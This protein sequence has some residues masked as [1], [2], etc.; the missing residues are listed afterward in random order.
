MSETLW[1][2]LSAYEEALDWARLEAS[3]RIVARGHSALSS[4]PAGMPCKLVVAA[5]KVSW[6]RLSPPGRRRL[7]GRS[8][9][10]A[11]EDRL[12]DAPEAVH[13]VMGRVDEDGTA[14]V[15]VVGQEWFAGALA[16]LE[17]QGLR[18]SS[19]LPEPAL[20]PGD[21]QSWHLVWG[22]EPMLRMPDGLCLQLSPDPATTR[23]LLE[24][25]LMQAASPPERLV[26]HAE[27]GETLPDLAN[28]EESPLPRM[29]SLETTAG[30]SYDW[31]AA[32]QAVTRVDVELMQG[33][34]ARR[35]QLSA[36]SLLAWRPAAILAGALVAVNLLGLLGAAGLKVWQAHKIEQGNRMLLQSSFPEIKVVLDPVLQM[37]QQLAG[38][39]HAS[40]SASATDFLPMLARAGSVLP[41]S[42]RASVREL[43]FRPGGLTLV[44]PTGQGMDADW[45][46]A[47]LR[48]SRRPAEEAGWDE[49]TLEEAA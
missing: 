22:G 39:S 46:Q 15:A 32:A 11:L 34:F 26:L 12:A 16:Q 17:E 28:P 13:A 41:D 4:L 36:E 20:L 14:M 43:R 23:Q 1:I 5:D 49:L 25:A 38:L 29:A 37:R 10:Y 47:G 8:L 18:P 45:Q 3:G 31:A 7:S 24:L 27:N 2:R 48:A 9:A 21:G 6:M 33:P 19:A 35:G 44:L 42:V 30:R 40:G